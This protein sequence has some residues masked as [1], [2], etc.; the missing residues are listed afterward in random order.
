MTDVAWLRGLGEDGLA[1]LLR[2][3]PE[4]LA[5]PSPVSLAELAD[6]LAMP[7]SVVAVMRRLDRPTLQVG[8]AIAAL[9]GR[10]ERCA[11]D[12][13]LGATSAD[14]QGAVTVALDR[15]RECALLAPGPGLALVLAA[16]AAWPRPLGL[17]PSVAE[18]LGRRTA[19][20]LRSVA[21]NLGRK[22]AG[23]RAEIFA[24][25]VAALRDPALVCAVVERAPAPARELLYKVAVTGEEVHDHQ[26][27]TSY[28]R[29]Q[30]PAQWAIAHG[31]L[32][33]A[34]DW[35]SGLSMPAEVAL[36]L[37]GS[38]YVAPF[39]P[40]PPLVGRAEV[41][42]D[43]VGRDAAA[44]GSG[45]VRLVAA[46]LDEAGRTSLATLKSGDIGTRELRRVAKR[47]GCT[48]PELRLVVPV[49]VHAGV[50]SV[51]DGRAAPTDGYDRWLRLEPAGRLAELLAA[52]WRLPYAPL[53]G[54]VRSTFTHRRTGRRR[55]G[56]RSLA[57][58]GNARGVAW[59][60]Q[61]CS[62]R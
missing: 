59:P 20:D 16:A 19:D 13:L 28:Q 8:E 47:L 4:A 32:V 27:F 49:A 41:D 18:V 6:R 52:W 23:R 37:R 11:L 35:E 50:L 17:G 1:A 21:R 58:P 54:T 57:S 60:S 26:Y 48:D 25:V 36:A 29:V 39:D 53:A 34:G 15:S 5:A 9:G 61:R 44:A 40:V 46:L 56:P 12:R 22:P 2:H 51:A 30:T 45:T 33:R 38:G 55:R 7:A 14:L 62:L 31:M 10:T 3:R 42:P 24:Q 43:V